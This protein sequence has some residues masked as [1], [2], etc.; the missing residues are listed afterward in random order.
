M[1]FLFIGR[2]SNIG[3]RARAGNHGEIPGRELRCVGE[4][5]LPCGS[6]LS[7]GGA[8]AARAEMLACGAGPSGRKR[9]WLAGLRAAAAGEAGAFTGLLGRAG[10]KTAR[11]LGRALGCGVWAAGERGSGWAAWGVS[12]LP[13]LGWEKGEWAMARFGLDWAVSWVSCFGFGL[14]CFGFG[15]LFY[16]FFSSISKFKKSLNSNTN[17]N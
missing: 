4:T 14:G 9:R 2:R 10:P 17:L 3:V 6:R 7:V 12:G 5:E 11:G 16:F 13:G 15:F 1:G 8:R